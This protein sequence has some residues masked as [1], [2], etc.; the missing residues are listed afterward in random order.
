MSTNPE[1]T[2]KEKE[3]IKQVDEVKDIMNNNIS[4][5]VKNIDNLEVLHDKSDQMKES[6]NQF[7]KGATTMKNKMWWK[8]IKL[9]LIILCVIIVIIVI[10]ILSLIPYFKK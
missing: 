2:T 4:K 10:I 3:L 1:K 6:S 5:M 7:R 9:Q 8:N